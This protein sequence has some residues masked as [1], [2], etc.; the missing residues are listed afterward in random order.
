MGGSWKVLV[1]R[2]VA[3]CDEGCVHANKLIFISG[4][5]HPGV[6]KAKWGLYWHLLFGP[7]SNT[8]KEYVLI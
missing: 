1:M 8:I 7:I 5:C 3:G 2:I 4:H 6:E